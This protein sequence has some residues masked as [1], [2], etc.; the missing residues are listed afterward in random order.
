MINKEQ[1]ANFIY[2]ETLKVE[3][4]IANFFW[5]LFILQNRK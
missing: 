1:M 4:K 5:V 3:L 2:F